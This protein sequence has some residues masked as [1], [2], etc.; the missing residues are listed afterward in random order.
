MRWRVAT[1][2]L[3]AT[4]LLLAAVAGC[5]TGAAP[6]Q[7]STSAPVSSVAGPS[8]ASTARPQAPATQVYG[9]TVDDLADVPAVV[10]SLRALGRPV[11][12]RV[13]FDVD[14]SAPTDAGELAEPVR[15]LAAV[16]T[17]YG[18]LVD[19]EELAR[20]SV[21]QVTERTAAYLRALGPWVSV[22]EVG[23]EVNGSWTGAGDQVAAKV[24][25]AYRQVR[26]VGGRTALTLYENTGCG[27]GPDE[28]DPA[29]WS[30][31]WLPAGIRAGL[32]Y[33]LLS[34]YEKQCGSRRPSPAEWT[35]KFA[36]LHPLFPAAQVGFGEVGLPKPATAT[37]AATAASI[38]SYYYRL[39]VEL[40]Y[41]VGGGF[42]WYYAEDMVPAGRPLWQA[43]RE[44]ITG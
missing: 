17:V 12:V 18:E 28:L 8:P 41:Y 19:S 25:A 22:W 16:A 5:R 26:A 4:F 31:R 10:A 44:A 39:P 21:D 23:N 27:D 34:Y 9:V 14:M 43:L 15:E 13:V 37:T 24:G 30:A 29:T 11:A 7:P 33:V 32:D 3:A 2:A 38:V 40:P 35:Q 20:I 42:Y 1:T 6:T 36:S